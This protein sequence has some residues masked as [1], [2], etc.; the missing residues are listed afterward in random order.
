MTE[1][2]SFQEWDFHGPGGEHPPEAEFREGAVTV[3][4]RPEDIFLATVNANGHRMLTDEPESVGGEDR[5]PTPYDYLAAALGTC[6]VMTLNMYA[7]HKRLPVERVE[8]SVRHDRV[9]ARDCKDCESDKGYVDQLHREIRITGE[10]DDAQRERMMQIAD[11]CPVHK[12][13][14]GEIKVRSRLLS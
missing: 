12:S 5:G 6:T 3:A 2:S 8:V 4:G 13:L 9:H 10:L 1:K 11:R 7:R 14:H